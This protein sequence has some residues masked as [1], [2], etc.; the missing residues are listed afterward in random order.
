MGEN[1]IR[2]K[3]EIQIKEHNVI[4]IDRNKIDVCTIDCVPLLMGKDMIL[5]Q[6]LY[7]YMIDGYRIIRMSDITSI[8]HNDVDRFSKEILMKEKILDK[9]KSSPIN[10][11]DNFNNIFQQ[12]RKIGKNI[13]I[14]IE[15]M[16]STDLYI[17]QIKEVYDDSVLFWNF[18]GLGKWDEAPARIYFHDITVIIFDDRYSTIIS[19]YIPKLI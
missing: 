3:L 10:N 4:R 5:V 17:G 13:V 7:D 16:D 15:T 2:K 14:E 8:H 11:I 18:D 6:Y 12:L 19:K 1:D 9:I